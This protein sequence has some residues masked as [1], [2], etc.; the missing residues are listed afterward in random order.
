M[1]KE[2]LHIG[3]FRNGKLVDDRHFRE[4]G[5]ITVGRS[6]GTDIW[7]QGSKLPEQHTLVT[8]ERGTA[9]LHVVAGMAGE[10]ALDGKVRQ[11]LEALRS[12]GQA[13]GAGWVIDLPDT[14]R[15]FVTLGDATF[16]LQ[17]GPKPPP[18]PK[19]TLPASART[20]VLSGLERT[21]STVFAIA[22]ALEA[23]T[24]VIINKRPDMS[25]EA[26]LEQEDLDRFA[27]I[28]MP[29]KKPEEVKKEDDSAKKAE[30]DA[31]KKA[32]EDAKKKEE[33]ANKKEDKKPEGEPDQAAK[34][35]KHADDVKKAVANSKLLQVLGSAGG[36]GAIGNVFA[37]NK[38]F[39]SDIADALNGAGG[40]KVA[41]G[42][43]GPEHKGS[44]G[45]GGVVGIGD[46]S[47]GAGGGGGHGTLAE[48][49]HVS[50]PRITVDDSDVEIESTSVDKDALNKFIKGRIR[51]IT[52]CYEK[53]LKLSPTLKGKIV[54]RFTVT[55]AGRTGEASI[56]ADTMHA[57][58]VSNCIIRTIKSWTYPFKPEEDV[59]VSFPFVFQPGG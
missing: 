45:G 36:D 24:V 17:L 47:A 55:T 7:L 34:A 23:A 19:R 53:E 43:D 44:A 2:F 6:A 13:D 5:G 3:A 9:K 8:F 33:E 48:K 29:D 54:V 14:V 52:A 58:N 56:D 16:F 25:P 10:L 37:S 32:A 1:A 39:N 50:P 18:P 35:Q 27:E 41:T 51:S 38:G 28:T 42:D 12:K 31:A 4:K 11:P 21:F 26:P 59:P 30:E 57:D 46:L 49:A 40:V 20:G 22:F 15:G